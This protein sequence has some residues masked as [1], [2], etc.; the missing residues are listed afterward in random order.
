VPR[1][2]YIHGTGAP[3]QQRLVELNRLTNDAFV[4][5]LDVQPAMSVLE[6]G[7]GLGILARRVAAIAQCVVGLEIS[8]AQISMAGGS[9]GVVFVQ[10]DAQAIPFE[11]ATFDLVYARYLLEHVSDPPAVLAEIHRV[12]RPGGRVAILEN[13]VTLIRFDPPC[14]MFDEVWAAFVSLQQRLGGDALIGRRLFRLFHAAGFREVELSVQ[15]EVHWFGSPSWRAW[16]TNIIGNVES[17]RTALIEQDLCTRTTVDAAIDELRG[18]ADRAD[19][20]AVFVWNRA[21]GVRGATSG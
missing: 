19:G 15:P 5:F 20:S 6:V 13:D 9:S 14:R 18:L 2:T 11:N 3:E 12:L 16:V 4:G 10:G 1:A 8:W 17:A 21:R 7:S